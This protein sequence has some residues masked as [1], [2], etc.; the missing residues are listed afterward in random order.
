MLN[1]ERESSL[2]KENRVTERPSALISSLRII[3]LY[4]GTKIGHLICEF[5]A[6]SVSKRFPV[7]NFSYEN[8]FDLHENEHAGE[9]TS[10]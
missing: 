7:Q 9:N 1:V 10:S 2:L 5:P 8:E 6:A 4:T 3:A